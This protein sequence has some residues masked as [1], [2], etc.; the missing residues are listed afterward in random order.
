MDLAV[1]AERYELG[2]FLINLTI[3]LLI[4]VLNSFVY[5]I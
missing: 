3:I 4:N 5:K 2:W 1:W